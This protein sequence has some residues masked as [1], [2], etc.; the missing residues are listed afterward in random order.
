MWACCWCSL[1][2]AQALRRNRGDLAT[3]GTILAAFYILW[4]YQRTMHG[5]T[6]RPVQRMRELNHREVWAVA[7]LLMLIVAFGV[8][9][10][11]CST[12]SPRPS[13]AP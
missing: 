5:P 4:M 2:A 12:S 9:P 11:R 3:L 7:P 6:P 8:Y 13:R 10:S 1:L